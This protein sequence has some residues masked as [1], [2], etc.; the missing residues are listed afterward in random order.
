[1]ARTGRSPENGIAEWDITDTDT[2]LVKQAFS[3]RFPNAT[4]YVQ[5]R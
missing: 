2:P 1:M 4:T 3:L 5:E